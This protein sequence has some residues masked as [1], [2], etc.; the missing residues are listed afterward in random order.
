MK[1]ADLEASANGT[2]KTLSLVGS[3]FKFKATAADAARLAK[4]FDVTG[5][6]AAP[7]T[8]QW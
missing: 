1:V 6:P 2:L 5:V 8:S 4:V 7:L 3:T